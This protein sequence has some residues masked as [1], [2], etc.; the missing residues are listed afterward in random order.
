MSLRPALLDDLGL[1][2]ALDW[3]LDR[4][5]RQTRVRVQFRHSGLEHRLPAPI[6]N[7][8]FRIVQEALTN[9]A[10]YAGVDAA[11]VRAE[12]TPHELRVRVEDSGHGFEPSALPWLTGGLLGMRE[13]A[14]AL[15]GGLSIESA[16]GAGTRITASMPLDRSGRP[17]PEAP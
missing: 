11:S 7:A 15:G 6:E 13:R 17:D 16:P 10:R 3:H 12:A 8:A 1:L 9:V 5:T 14:L 4:Y 2:P